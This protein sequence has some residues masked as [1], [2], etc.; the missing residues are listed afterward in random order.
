M[1]AQ[2]RQTHRSFSKWKDATTP[3]TD[4]PSPQR[5]ATQRGYRTLRVAAWHWL[6]L[7]DPRIFWVPGPAMPSM[8]MVVGVLHYMKPFFGVSTACRSIM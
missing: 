7:V 5:H 8:P 2:G 6:L 3:R 4:R 1:V